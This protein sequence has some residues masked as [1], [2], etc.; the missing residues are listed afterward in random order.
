MT[1][2]RTVD[3]LVI[4]ATI[5]GLTTAVAAAAAGAAVLVI[6]PGEI[7]RFGTGLVTVAMGS[8]LREV[9]LSRG[10]PA[11]ETMVAEVKRATDWLGETLPLYGAQLVDRTAYS[12]AVDGHL[13][14][15]L[16]Q[17]ARLL[18]RAG[19]TVDFTDGQPLAPLVT[20]P[21]I[22]LPNQAQVEPRRH[23]HALGAA[24]VA[25]GVEVVRE[26]TLGRFV[27]GRG[28]SVS[29]QHS[30]GPVTVTSPTVID[31]IGSAPWGP[32]AGRVGT[33]LRVCP[34]VQG[35]AG[36]F[37]PDIHVL[38]DT[39]AAMVTTLRQ[40]T[41]LVG[42]PVALNDEHAATVD[43]VALAGRLGLTVTGVRARHV[44]LTADHLPRVGR[45]PLLD[46]AWLARGFGMWETTLATAAGLQLGA[47]VT[48]TSDALPWTPVRLPAPLA[49]YRQWTGE[50][51]DPMVDVPGILKR[52]GLSS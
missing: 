1:Q 23:R 46:G 13:A 7:T 45:V 52:R 31:T 37:P 2:Q 25:A 18:R 24:A 21:G 39:P 28:W 42:H 47:A 10:I 22:V 27:P 48:G 19:V 26:V 14:F 43:L 8:T 30:S 32:V 34:V 4:G 50:N 11:A 5:A 29:Y 40:H 20:R 17:E 16:R 49:A 41:V 33:T 6:D 12:L 51:S 38:V 44:E 15:H 3:V 36:F 35:S 9:E